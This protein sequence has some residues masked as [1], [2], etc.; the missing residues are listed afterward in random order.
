MTNSKKDFFKDLCTDKDLET[1]GA[2]V[3]L[4]SFE[5]SVRVARAN[6]NEYR[7]ALVE[8]L[9]PFRKYENSKKEP[10]EFIIKEREEAVLRAVA[11]HVF[12]EMKNFFSNGKEIEN[13][14]EN[15]LRMLEDTDFFSN[16]MEAAALRETFRNEARE[17][18]AK[19]LPPAI[20]GNSTT[21]NEQQTE[22]SS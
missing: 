18:E 16:V 11:E 12:L 9:K 3:F 15:R 6:N 21:N 13:T 22:L 1:K 2:W 8:A 7:K 20:D 10:P 5:G 4:D 17:D 14:V 19:N